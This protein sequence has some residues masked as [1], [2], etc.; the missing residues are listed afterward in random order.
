MAHVI[1]FALGAF[2][3]SLG[4]NGRTESSDAHEGDQQFGEK[5]SIDIE[6]SQNL[7]TEGN[8]RINMVSALRPGLAKI[9][10]KYVI[11]DILKVL[12]LTF[13]L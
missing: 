11:H 3:S 13:R 10:E 9:I 8:A 1:Q 2:I 12:K 6:Q 5:E 4:G 7:R